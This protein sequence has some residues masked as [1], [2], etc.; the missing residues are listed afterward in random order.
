MSVPCAIADRD[1]DLVCLLPPE[2][3]L[4]I[5]LWLVVHRELTRTAR[6]RAVMDFLADAVGGSGQY[7]SRGSREVGPKPAVRIVCSGRRL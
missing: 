7:E 6:V 2:R 5:E 4:S 1:P 3:V